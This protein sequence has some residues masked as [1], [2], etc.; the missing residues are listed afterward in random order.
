MY[1]ELSPPFGYFCAFVAKQSKLII[2]I[3]AIFFILKFL[4]ILFS[5]LSD[6]V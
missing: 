4:M 3:I 6:H 1:K 2:I 5:N